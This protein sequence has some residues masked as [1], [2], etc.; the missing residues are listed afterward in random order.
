ML[1]TWQISFKD[2]G[3]VKYAI[4]PV[5]ADMNKLNWLELDK[6][7][8]ISD[9]LVINTD[10]NDT[11]FYYHN[12]YNIWRMQFNHNGHANGQMGKITLTMRNGGKSN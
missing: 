5:G 6:D 4:H 1:I 9:P 8:R 3:K 7:L 11:T 12:T 10:S 2:D